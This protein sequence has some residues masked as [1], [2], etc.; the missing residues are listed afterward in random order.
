MGISLERMPRH[1]KG[2]EVRLEEMDLDPGTPGFESVMKT[3]RH[4]VL[5]EEIES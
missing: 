3:V 5:G 4:A 2:N 1:S